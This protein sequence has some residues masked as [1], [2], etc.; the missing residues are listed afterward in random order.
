MN[1][2]QM[3]INAAAIVRALAVAC[4][5]LVAASL[6]GQLAKYWGGRPFIYGLV[7]MFYVGAERN[8]PTVFSVLL[9]SFAALLLALVARL[10]AREQSP[11][12][13]RWMLLAGGFLFMAFDEG[14]QVHE[15]FREPMRQLLG[16]NATGIFNFAWVIPFGLLV[17]VLAAYFLKFV[18]SLPRRTAVFFVLAGALFVGGSIGMELVGGAYAELHGEDNPTY[19]LMST[20][21]ETMEMAGVI[22]FIHALLRYIAECYPGVSLHFLDRAR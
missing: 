12:T 22:V 21:E 19:M 2:N 5:L 16:D 20:V 1:N 11:Y 15:V 13:A 18:L 4:A 17:L 14:G 9:L 6:A 3:T 10:K 8:V 7:P